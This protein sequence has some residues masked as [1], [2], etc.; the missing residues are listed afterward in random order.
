MTKDHIYF[1]IQGMV[2]TLLASMLGAKPAWS[3][4]SVLTW[5]NDN[6]A[7]VKIWPKPFLPPRMS[8]RR[9]SARNVLT[10]STG[11][12]MPSHSTCPA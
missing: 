9:I 7:P 11:R 5:H 4:V 12:S 8:T 2:I 3:Q 1:V 6:A 10:R